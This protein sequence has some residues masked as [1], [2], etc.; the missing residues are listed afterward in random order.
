MIIEL[1][2]IPI[3]LNQLY[4]QFRGRTIIS[5]KGRLFKHHLGEILSGFDLSGLDGDF[6]ETEGLHVEIEFYSKSFYTKSGKI[7]KRF[8]DI[9]NL[10]KA[11]LDTIFKVIDLDDSLI[12]K[13]I[14]TKNHGLYD[15]TVIRISRRVD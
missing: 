15:R 8:L 2:L 7:R 10:L 9:D 6:S 14:V 1:D 12:T 13:M 3:S 5:Q 4:R 11:T